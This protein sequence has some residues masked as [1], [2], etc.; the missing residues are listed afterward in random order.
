MKKYSRLI[1]MIIS[2]ILIAQLI[3]VYS[4]ACNERGQ[5]ETNRQETLKR[6]EN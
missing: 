1:L 2:L 5:E 4:K 3:F 6:P